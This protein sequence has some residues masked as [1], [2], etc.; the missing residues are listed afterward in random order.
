M[1]GEFK[2]EEAPGSSREM[3]G[4]EVVEGHTQAE[5]MCAS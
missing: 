5:G 4:G 2:K 1:D 3:F